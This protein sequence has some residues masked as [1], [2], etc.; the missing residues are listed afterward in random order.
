[1]LTDNF[2]PWL[3]QKSRKISRFYGSFN[4][5]LID[6]VLL[7]IVALD[8]LKIVNYSFAFNQSRIL[9]EI[10]YQIIFNDL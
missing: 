10:N 4:T 3:T 5:T 8:L 9:L 7:G 6:K 1:M 2:L